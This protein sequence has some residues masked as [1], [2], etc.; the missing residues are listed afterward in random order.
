MLNNA[1]AVIGRVDGAEGSNNGETLCLLNDLDESGECDD[2]D[3]SGECDDVDGGID[4]ATLGLDDMDD[5]LVLGIGLA[6]EE[7]RLKLSF[8]GIPNCTLTVTPGGEI[9]SL[10]FTF[11]LCSSIMRAISTICACK[12]EIFISLFLS[13]SSCV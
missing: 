13:F 5:L 10:P 12:R 9:L 2:V 6:L 8:G 3:E 11:A 4:T 7:P 1:I